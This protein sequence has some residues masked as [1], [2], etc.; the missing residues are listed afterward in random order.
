MAKESPVTQSLSNVR[1]GQDGAF[2]KLVSLLYD[3]LRLIAAHHLD[4]NAAQR[5]LNPTGLVHEA[6]LRL[7]RREGLTWEDRS[8]FFAACSVVMRNIV[9]DFARRKK[10][11]KR[12]GGLERITFNEH[13]IRIDSQVEDL[14]A[15]DEALDQLDKYGNRLSRVVECRF[16]AGLTEPETA[17]A[18]GVSERTV[19]RDWIKARTLLRS[20]LS[21]GPGDDALPD[22]APA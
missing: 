17:H 12:A 18:L 1:A 22:G 5:T 14:L 19:R 6:Y 15:L 16:F 3:D 13:E 7:A 10:T 20:I 21:D 8:H 4:P 2:E 9:I 11:A